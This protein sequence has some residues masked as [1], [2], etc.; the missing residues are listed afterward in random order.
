MR[1]LKRLISLALVL[2]IA[3]GGGVM[4][5]VHAQSTKGRTRSVTIDGSKANRKE[6]ML[7]KGDVTHIFHFHHIKCRL[8]KAVSACSFPAWHKQLLSCKEY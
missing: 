7:Y 2:S 4:E 5:T 8:D 6:N 3:G 1:A